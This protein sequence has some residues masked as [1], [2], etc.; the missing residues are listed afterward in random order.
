MKLAKITL[1]LFA[2]KWLQARPLCS[3][4]FAYMERESSCSVFG[5]HPVSRQVAYANVR[6]RGTLSKQASFFHGSNPTVAY[7]RKEKGKLVGPRETAILCHLSLSVRERL[8]ARGYRV[9]QLLSVRLRDSC[10]FLS[11]EQGPCDPVYVGSKTRPLFS[12]T[13]YHRREAKHC[14]VLCYD[15]W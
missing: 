2:T 12:T 10:S 7:G 11:P 14:C 6:I 8:C 13:K 9:V 15:D 4:V 1:Y 3:T 5:N